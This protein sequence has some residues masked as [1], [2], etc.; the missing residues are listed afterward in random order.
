MLFT[1]I[2]LHAWGTLSAL[3]HDPPR[4]EPPSSS[5]IQSG[6]CACT[7]SHPVQHKRGNKSG[8]LGFPEHSG[9]TQPTLLSSLL[10]VTTL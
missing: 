10:S 1:Q 7:Q 6:T 2:G 5:I 8:P 3:A 9:L 4:C